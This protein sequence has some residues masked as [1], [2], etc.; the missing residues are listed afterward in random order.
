MIANEIRSVSRFGHRHRTRGKGR[1][2]LGIDRMSREARKRFF[3]AISNGY[4]RS[5]IA[6]SSRDGVV[7]SEP[8]GIRPGSGL[9]VFP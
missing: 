7:I 8:L 4:S 5:R 3:G 9:G 1:T 2:P 6:S